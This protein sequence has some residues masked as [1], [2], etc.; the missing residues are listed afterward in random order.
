[1]KFTPD[2]RE[3]VKLPSGERVVLRLIRPEDRERL[4]EG[5]AHLSLE[6]RYYRFFAAK[7]RLSPSELKYLTE[8]D[9]VNHVA[10]GAAL[11]IG[12][13]DHVTEGAGMAVARFVR[14]PDPPNVA[15]A[16][17][18]VVDEWKGKR[19]GRLLFERLI[20]AARERGIEKLRCEVLAQNESMRQLLRHIAPDAEE[21]ASIDAELMGGGGGDVIVV[22]LPIPPPPTE[23]GANVYS[24]S[25]LYKILVL[26]AQ[27]LVIVRRAVDWLNRL[28]ESVKESVTH[29][30]AVITPTHP[31]DEKK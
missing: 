30:V 27:R 26:A 14:L 31:H 9:N 6:T 22:D 17:I 16:A 8:T 21:R 2:Y 11:A 4:A 25:A 12:E 18:V 19:L 13:G 7:E 24:A 3:I 28:Q 20:E 1:M 15:E 5:F 10:F 23:A 29:V